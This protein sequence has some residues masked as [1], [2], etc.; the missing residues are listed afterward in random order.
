MQKVHDFG[1]DQVKRFNR[2][3]IV[4]VR[5]PYRAV[6]SFHNYLFGGHK[7]MAPSSNY[8]RKGETSERYPCKGLITSGCEAR[9]EFFCG[10]REKSDFALPDPTQPDPVTLLRSPMSD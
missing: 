4:I 8:L 10:L 7:G 2:S 5:N 1:D 6:L 9:S 3:A